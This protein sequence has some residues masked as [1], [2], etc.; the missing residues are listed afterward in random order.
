MKCSKVF[1]C[2]GLFLVL[3]IGFQVEAK[4]KVEPAPN[5]VVEEVIEPEVAVEE[6]V[7]VEEEAE[8][9]VV[10]EE[11]VRIGLTLKEENN[12]IQIVLQYSFIYSQ[13][14]LKHPRLP[15]IR[16]QQKKRRRRKGQ[17]RRRQRK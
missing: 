13:N 10:E 8:A 14:R 3:T 2:V 5:E 4:A 15:K 16:H 17:L 11:K 12:R 7:V 6:E 9:A 1:L